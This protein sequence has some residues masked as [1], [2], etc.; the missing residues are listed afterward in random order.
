[1]RRSL[2]GWCLSGL[3]LGTISDL[4]YFLHYLLLYPRCLKRISEIFLSELNGHEIDLLILIG[5]VVIIS[6][7][8]NY[9]ID[10]F[11]S[12]DEFAESGILAV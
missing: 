11:N 5:L 4:L 12:L 3:A 6:F 10:F 9:L 1:M 7:S 8:G 2:L